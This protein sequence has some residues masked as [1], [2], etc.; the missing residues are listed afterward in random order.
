MEIYPHF[1]KKSFIILQ[2][3]ARQSSLESLRGVTRIDETRCFSQ[4]TH[5]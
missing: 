2:L 3:K 5:Q 4:I 1:L